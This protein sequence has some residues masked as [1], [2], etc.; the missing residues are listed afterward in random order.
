MANA[1][2]ASAP[3]MVMSAARRATLSMTGEYVT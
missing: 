1:A 3:V 2:A